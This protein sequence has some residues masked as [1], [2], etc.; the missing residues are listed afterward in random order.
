MPITL[1]RV[2]R[3]AAGRWGE[4]KSGV[5]EREAAALLLL[6]QKR[7]EVGPAAGYLPKIQCECTIS[8]VESDQRQV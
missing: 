4:E 7:G 1:F 3:R 8:L 2:D 5:W 6:K